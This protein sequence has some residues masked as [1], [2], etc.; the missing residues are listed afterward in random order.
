[1]QLKFFT[2][3]TLL[4][5]TAVAPLTTAQNTT[6]NNNDS[7]TTAPST[8]VIKDNLVDIINNFPGCS[9]DCL[10]FTMDR[11]R[12]RVADL[13]CQC[14]YVWWIVDILSSCPCVLAPSTHNDIRARMYDLCHRWSEHP[15]PEEVEAAKLRYRKRVVDRRDWIDAPRGKGRTTAE[16]GLALMGGAIA[17]VAAAALLL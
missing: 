8:I 14:K 7:N 1:M 15:P 12:C 2:T 6:T 4:G 3:L 9:L 10:S 5:A 13:N 11:A 16:R 17:A